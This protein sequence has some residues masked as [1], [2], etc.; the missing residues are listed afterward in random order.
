MTITRDAVRAVHLGERHEEGVVAWSG[1]TQDKTLAL[2]TAK[3]TDAV[4]TF[5]DP[6]Y[7]ERAVRAIERDAGHPVDDPQTAVATV[8]QRLR[9]TDAQQND[10]LTHFIRGGDVTAGGI[11]HAVTAA[12]QTQADA[13]TAHDMESAALRALEIA[14]TL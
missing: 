6:R 13:D 4:A 2:I 5:L 3:T 10:I 14:A 7:A 11:M 12:A 9:F 8:S 1:N